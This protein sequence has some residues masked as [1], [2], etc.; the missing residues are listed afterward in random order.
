[1]QRSRSNL[2][3]IANASIFV[4]LLIYLV[5]TSIYRNLPPLIGIFFLYV[6]VLKFEEDNKFK[7]ISFTWYF[8]IFY[9]FITEQI[10][11][12]KLF[13]ILISYIFAYFLLFNI[14]L[15]IIKFRNL[16]IIIYICYGYIMPFCVSNFIS[17]I[18]K[19]EYL[20]FTGDYLLYIFIEIV[21]GIVLFR[22]KFV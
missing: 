20:N 10:H 19:D 3:L 7:N 13:S 11:G 12:Y 1:M 2:Y 14:S 17:Y 22:G 9:L 8:A 15:K 21:L 4:L 5:A 6:I 16:L 18:Q